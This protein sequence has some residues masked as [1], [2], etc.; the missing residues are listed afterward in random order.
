MATKLQPLAKRKKFRRAQAGAN[1]A[2][3]PGTVQVS[4]ILLDAKKGQHQRGNV[5][6]S[7]RLANCRVT[8]V[9]ESLRRWLFAADS[10]SAL[11][12]VTLSHERSG[13]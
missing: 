13:P 5:T 6:R 10:T 11:P 12:H 9:A 7:F 1:T 3:D 8:E 2:D 4:V